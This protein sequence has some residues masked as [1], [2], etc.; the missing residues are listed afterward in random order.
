MNRLEQISA[1]MD[2]EADQ[3]AETIMA[4]IS[5]DPTLRGAW[6][7]YHLIGDAMRGQ[8]PGHLT[9]PE[10]AASIAAAVD[11]E[12]AILSPASRRKSTVQRA[13]KPVAG[14][15]IAASVAMVAI[16]GLRGL[17]EATSTSGSPTVAATE[18]GSTTQDDP[19]QSLQPAPQA[20]LART[21]STDSQ[22]PLQPSAQE[23]AGGQYGF[24][25]YLI[26]HNEYR[27]NAGVRGIMPYARIVAPNDNEQ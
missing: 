16:I 25:S 21:V 14:L 22:P 1:F 4:G 6:Q 2:G 8:L 18:S 7:R 9:G 26:N 24:S 23:Q 13:L 27:A 3:P 11:R 15:A 19:V 12:P 5:N 20:P 17:N 10:L